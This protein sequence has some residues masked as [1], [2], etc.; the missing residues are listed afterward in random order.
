MY[1]DNQQSHKMAANNMNSYRTKHI[2]IKYHFIRDAGINGKVVI[3]YLPTWDMIADS[4]TKLVSAVRLKKLFVGLL[5][6]VGM[7]LVG[8][9]LIA[10]DG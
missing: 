7:L 10:D 6:F 1:N 3:K 2:Y 8:L 4:S 9:L 5:Q